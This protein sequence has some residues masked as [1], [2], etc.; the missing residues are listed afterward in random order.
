MSRVGDL[1]TEKFVASKQCQG[2]RTEKMHLGRNVDVETLCKI[3]NF[4]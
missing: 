1:M 2:K 3:I 4:V